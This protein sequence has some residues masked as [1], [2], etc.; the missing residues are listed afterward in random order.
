MRAGSDQE[1]SSF[2]G[3]HDRTAAWEL[4]VELATRVSAVP[5]PEG[6]GLL[7]EALA[8]L[9]VLASG[10]R[11]ILREHRVHLVG[12]EPCPIVVLAGEVARTLEELLA[13][14]QPR[15]EVLAA[16][17]PPGL[18]PVELERNWPGAAELRADL[19]RVR[20]ELRSAAERLAGLAGAVSLLP[21]DLDAEVSPA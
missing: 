13:R 9:D 5:L 12:G 19:A 6:G 21:P 1:V 7:S 14:W 11:E 4:H 17:V 15:L 16:G 20:G 8:S 2:R 18:D 3:G 10:C